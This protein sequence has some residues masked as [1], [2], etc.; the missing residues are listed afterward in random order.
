MSYLVV[1]NSGT[2]RLLFFL[3][4]ERT[5]LLAEAK[6]QPPVILYGILSEIWGKGPT[7]LIETCGT[8]HLDPSASL[9]SW[10][11]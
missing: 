5:K 10:R 1:G 8:Y 9:C 4:D 11:K 7:S 3:Q 6:L 2:K